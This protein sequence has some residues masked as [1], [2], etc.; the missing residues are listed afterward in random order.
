[1]G[2][3][4]IRDII[5]IGGGPAGFTAGMYAARSRMDTLLLESF[6]VMG[7]ATM[8]DLIENYPGVERSSGYDLVA[9]FKKQ[10]ESFG[11]ETG[12]GTVKSISVS[13]SGKERYFEVISD[14]G[15]YKAISLIVAT[16]A[17]SKKL[18]IPGEKDFLGKG[19]SYCAT[20]DGPFFRE[21]EV[22]VVGGGDTAVEEAIYLTR[23]AS[24]VTI[25]HR[26]D[27][28]RSAKILQERAEASEKIDFA[29]DS[30]VEEVQGE[31]KMSA[32]RLK[33]V[34]TGKETLLSCRGVF[35]FVGW[36]PNTGFLS[37]IVEFDR[38]GSVIVDSSMC[39][40]LPGLFAG[41]DCTSKVLH[42]VVTAAGDGATAAFSSQRYVEELKGVAYG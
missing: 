25:V 10:A 32:V 36:V 28:L 6:S 33:N 31:D 7:Q 9:G 42:Q 14:S 8:T 18:G 26:R 12:Q 39:S 20:C 5:I 38:G 30:V 13:G 15:E 19:V 35:V 24:K 40:S 34:K 37:D 2:N 4:K 23:F 16:G 1:M 11:L 22:V 41:G 21:M 17:C 27:R 29:W 3:E